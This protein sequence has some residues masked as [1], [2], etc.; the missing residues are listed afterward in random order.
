M[1]AGIK[2]KNANPKAGVSLQL[3]S[4][5]G[6][7]GLEPA[8]NGL[9]APV[10]VML[11]RFLFHHFV[12]IEAAILKIVLDALTC[13]FALSKIGRVLANFLTTDPPQ[14]GS[15][16]HSPERELSWLL[17]RAPVEPPRPANCQTSAHANRR[18]GRHG[19]L[20][21]LASA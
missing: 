7:A 9:K 4:L 10:A 21:P 16:S 14:F 18:P 1:L 3:N 5:V 20:A 15:Q 6:R 17:T 13:F 12:L 8:T 2:N 19:S 11:V